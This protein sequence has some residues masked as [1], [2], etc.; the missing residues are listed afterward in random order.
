MYLKRIEIN[1]FKSFA[2]KTEIILD[3]TV[4]GVVGPN[5]SGKSNIADAIRWVLGEQ[6]SKNLRGAKMEDVIFN[7]TDKRPRKAFAEVCLVFDNSDGRMHLDYSEILIARKMYRSGESEYYINKNLVRLKDV[8]EL[9][10]DTGIGKEGYSIIGQGRIDEILESRPTARRKVFEEAAGIMKFRARKEEAEK[11][12]EKTDDNL[13][14]IDDI[15]S[16]LTE[17]LE[18]LRV[19]AEQAREYLQLFERQKIVEAN[20]FL[21]N[22][23]RFTN[24]IEK[25]TEELA[26]ITKELDGLKQESGDS[27]EEGARLN[28]RLEKAN[29]ELNIISQQIADATQEAERVKGMLQLLEERKANAGQETRRL[30]TAGEEQE[31]KRAFLTEELMTLDEQKQETEHQLA[32][33]GEQYE[34]LSEEQRVLQEALEEQKSEV[35]KEGNLHA[36]ILQQIAEGQSLISAV[37]AKIE[38]IENRKKD[39]E[40]SIAV[41]Q[42]QEGEKNAALLAEQREM[43]NLKNDIAGIAGEIN[44]NRFKTNKIKEKKTEADQAAE[45]AKSAMSRAASEK[46]LLLD[47]KAEYDGYSESVRNLMRTARTDQEIRSRVIGTLAELVKVPREYE[48]AIETVLGNVLQNVV[49]ETEED[50]KYIIDTL[51]KKNLGR[52]SFMP[53]QAL[54]VNHLDDTER[55]ALSDEGC[56]AV[57]SDVLEFD[58]R[59]R[60][61]VE[62]ALARTVL[63]KDM[64]AAIRTMRKANYSFRTVT[65]K[66]DFIRPGGVITGGSTGSRQL[67][68]LSREHRLENAEKAYKAAQA[69]LVR[70]Q[71]AQEEIEKQ[72]TAARA[73]TEELIGKLSQLEIE[74]AERKERVNAI[75]ESIEAGNDREMQLNREYTEADEEAAQLAEQ[76]REY[77]AAQAELTAKAEEVKRRQEELAKRDD[78]RSETRLQLSEKIGNIRIRAAELNKELEANEA[79]RSRILQ[80]KASIAGQLEQNVNLLEQ[81]KQ[82]ADGYQNEIAKHTV[83]LRASES[84]LAGIREEY[85]K[86]EQERQ[87]LQDRVQK[88]NQKNSDSQQRQTALY[89]RKYK[90]ESQLEKTQILK[91][92]SQQKLW[93]DYELTYTGAEELKTDINYTTASREAESLRARI[94]ELGP[95]NPNAIEDCARLSERAD[96]LTAQRADLSAAK[97]DLLKVIESLMGS[98][99]ETFGQRFEQ[100]NEHF[101]RIFSDLFGGGRAELTMGEGDILEAGIEISA[102]PPGKKLQQLSLLSGGERALTAIAL[103][104]AMISINPSPLCLFDEIDAPLDEGNARLFAE[105]LR[106]IENTQFLIVTHRKSTMATCDSLYGVAMEEKG[107]SKL[108]SVKLK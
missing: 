27:A 38:A 45:Q 63:V 3:H 78:D 107:V 39:I 73:V 99:R 31:K 88:L 14:R 93:D 18:P 13:L 54:K 71:T 79:N 15:L 82:Q 12:L 57:A 23:D 51:R 106:K 85:T 55:R 30:Q 75:A 98:M 8:I 100:L 90:L 62:F 42:K 28:I 66:G 60:P 97:E 101:K 83:S 4:T 11:K 17:Q 80:E 32:E 9:M 70:A 1:G 22:F 25:I 84:A 92:N 87:Y 33:I 34:L 104:F 50:A 74:S 5:G 94:R 77:E 41:I 16:T 53:L 105:Y 36:Q 2:N 49:V 76:R 37:N 48:T 68:L 65:L 43:R 40:E 52:V 44:E 59:I 26:D 21:Y 102:E 35:G 20:L 86:K 69:E 24:R 103:L 72:L 7:G 47:L 19:Q 89:E 81:L 91:E 58:E 29:G 96:E 10:R 64:D 61:A 46:Q 67:G 56:I 108:V 6:S 95:I